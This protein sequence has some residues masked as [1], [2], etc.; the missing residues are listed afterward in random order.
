M[1][2]KLQ[3][4]HLHLSLFVALSLNILGSTQ[5]VYAEN[6]STSTRSNVA[7]DSLAS[8][9]VQC[10]SGENELSVTN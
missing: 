4:K 9:Q 8:V 7:F 2:M 3:R 1:M 5:F 10:F 6:D